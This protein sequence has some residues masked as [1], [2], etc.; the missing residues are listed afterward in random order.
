MPWYDYKC[1]A[2]D[3]EFTEVH[4]IDD[5]KIPVKKKCPKCGKKKVKQLLGLIA[6]VDSVNLGRTRPDNSYSEVISKINESEGIKGTRY[7][8]EDRLEQREKNKQNP[9]T[10]YEIKKSVN[11]NLK[12]KK[13]RGRSKK[14]KEK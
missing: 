7:E 12:A 11:D 5:R 1:Y 8:L 6:M 2:C 13:G 4:R 9:L 14:K 3:N 10:T